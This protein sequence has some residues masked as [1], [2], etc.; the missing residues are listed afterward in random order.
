MG[1]SESR[2]SFCLEYGERLAESSRK[3]G[4][5]PV[6]G[7]NG[8]IGY[9]SE[10]LIKGPGIVVGRKGTIGV[11]NWSERDFWSIDTTYYVEM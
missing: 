11:V 1:S 8:I 9:H 2:R 10:Y 3:E 5:Y 4:K 6:L 7:S